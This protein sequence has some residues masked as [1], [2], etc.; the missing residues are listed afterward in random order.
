MQRDR[1]QD[2]AI[3]SGHHGKH[4]ERREWQSAHEQQHQMEA[5]EHARQPDKAHL[6]HD[7]RA[8]EA[9]RQIRELRSRY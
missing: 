8:A 7:S 5:R 9:E 3:K 4:H 6:T 1:Y 2:A